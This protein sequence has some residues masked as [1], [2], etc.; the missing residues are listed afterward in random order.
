LGASCQGVLVASE[1]Q[2]EITKYMCDHPNDDFKTEPVNDLPELLQQSKNGKNGL[3]SRTR[4]AFEE[5]LMEYRKR[6]AKALQDQTKN[7]N[8]S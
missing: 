3:T 8:G 4:G 6:L 7:T 1:L 2:E 5:W